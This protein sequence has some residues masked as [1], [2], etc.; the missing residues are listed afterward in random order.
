MLERLQYSPLL[1]VIKA[2]LL[3][4]IALHLLQAIVSANLETIRVFVQMMILQGD[5]RKVQ[6]LTE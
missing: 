2:T 5:Y 1:R 3:F 4:L 6:L